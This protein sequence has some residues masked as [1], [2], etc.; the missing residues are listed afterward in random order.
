MGVRSRSD[1]PMGYGVIGNT[2]DSGSVVLGSSPSTPARSGPSGQDLEQHS[3]TARVSLRCSP[4]QHCKPPLCSGLARRPLKAVA[5]V[6]IRSGVQHHEGPGLQTGPFVVL[7]SGCARDE[8]VADPEVRHGGVVELPQRPACTTRVTGCGESQVAVGLEDV[9]ESRVD[10][11]AHV[12]HPDGPSRES[13]HVPARGSDPSRAPRHHQPGA[14]VLPAPSGVDERRR[15]HA[16]GI[17][18]VG[19]R[20]PGPVTADGACR[21]G[22]WCRCRSRPS[23]RPPAGSAAPGR[24]RR[25]RRPAGPRRCARRPPRRP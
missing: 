23:A 14:Y 22:C 25:P 11:W 1:T 13:F 17:V 20:P 10:Q 12:D 15:R 19:L 5:P 21:T 2:A 24:C 4:E 3:S 7:G 18:R 9:G 8:L 6:R 16:T